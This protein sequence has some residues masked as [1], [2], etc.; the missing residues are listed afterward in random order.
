[1]KPELISLKEAREIA[2]E[3]AQSD[4]AGFVS[5][6]PVSNFLDERYLEAENCWMFFIRKDLSF[7]EEA[8]LA[9]SA[10][11]A[12]SKHG[13]LRTVPDFSSE[14]ERLHSYLT[15]LSDHFST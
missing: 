8:T 11:F 10:A 15:M 7:P 2:E 3:L 14:P 12:V 6:A 4:L 1:M 9:A 13:V 5:Q